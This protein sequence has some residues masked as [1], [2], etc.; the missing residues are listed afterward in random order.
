MPQDDFSDTFLPTVIKHVQENKE[1]RAHMLDNITKLLNKSVPTPVEA[2]GIA[3]QTL[4]PLTTYEVARGIKRPSYYE[5]ANAAKAASLKY[6]VDLFDV[7][8]KGMDGIAQDVQ[9]ITN[10]INAQT[11]RGNQN[12]GKI[13]DV[14]SSMTASMDPS[15]ALLFSKEFLG[16]ISSLEHEPDQQELWNTA[17]K[18]ANALQL[19]PKQFKLPKFHKY[20]DGSGNTVSI[21]L[22]DESNEYNILDVAPPKPASEPVNRLVPETTI[23]TDPKTGVKTETTTWRGVAPGRGMSEPPTPLGTVGAPEEDLEGTEDT[24]LKTNKVTPAKEI[25]IEESGA[26][27]SVQAA[28]DTSNRVRNAI[29]KKNG[30]IDQELLVSMEMNIPRTNGRMLR[31]A[32][33]DSI[34][35]YIHLKS[36]KQVTDVERGQWL[37][38]FM[39]SILDNSAGVKDKL[40]RLDQFFRGSVGFLPPR[41]QDRLKWQG[42]GP[43]PNTSTTTNNDPIINKALEYYKKGKSK[44]ALSEWL[45]SKGKDPGTVQWQR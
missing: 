27:Q 28:I 4:T 11:L 16:R 1:Q 15:S 38:I 17:S 6:N 29:I 2:A 40:H 42:E 41:L 26:L 31:K 32:F 14:L 33:E 10:A 39:P 30:K 34:F 19:K 25:T 24:T 36:G 13:K 45:R 7:A 44:E 35:N 18:T 21:M 5:A 3:Q 23:M 20:T 8:D 43:D 9:V 12:T 22:D 37:S